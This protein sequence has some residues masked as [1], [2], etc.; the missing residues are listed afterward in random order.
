MSNE[1][2]GVTFMACAVYTKF[3]IFFTFEVK[4]AMDT[5]IYMGDSPKSGNI[6]VRSFC[7][8]IWIPFVEKI[9]SDIIFQS[10]QKVPTGILC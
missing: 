2:F 8:Y 5:H 1:H 4:S 3:F 6:T 7:E 9:E 10:F